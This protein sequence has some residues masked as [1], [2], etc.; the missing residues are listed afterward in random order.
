MPSLTW[1]PNEQFE[2]TLMANVQK[3]DGGTTSSFLPHRGTVLS[4]P[5]GEIGSERFVSEPG[6]DEYD[7]EQKALTSQMAWRVDDTWTLRQNLRWQKSKV[8]YQTMYGWPP[9]LGADNRTVNRVWSISKPE[10]TI[11]S[12][13]HQA[14][15]RFDTGPLQHTA[16]VGVDYRHAVT[17]SRTLAEPPPRWIFTI[18]STAHS[19]RPAS[20]FPMFRSSALPSRASMFRTRF[21]ST[22]GWQLW[23]CARTGLTLAL[24]RAPGRRT[25][26]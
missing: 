8:S 4:A 12:A 17:D 20:R 5:Y 25:M 9:V 18:R 15:S 3:D 23:A 24:S 26:R 10:V 7:T 2:W 21:V 22:S 14:E 19:I 13:D 1:R 11:W 6:F 16:L